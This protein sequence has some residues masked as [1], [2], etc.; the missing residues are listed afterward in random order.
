MAELIVQTTNLCKRYGSLMAVNGVAMSVEQGAIVGL[1]GKNGAGKTTLIRLLVGLTK[2]TSGTFSILPNRIRKSSSAAAIVEKPSLYMNM[3][4]I[5]NLR[6]QCLLLDISADDEFLKKTLQVVGLKSSTLKVKNFSLGMKQ[7]LAIAMSFVGK[8]ELLL[9]DEPTNGLD[10]Q[11]IFEVREAFV[12]LNKEF[13][14]TIIVSSHILSELS[15]FATEYYFMDKGRI[16]KHASA[17]EINNAVTRCLRLTVDDP[18]KAQS[19]LEQFGD[20]SVAG[21]T[22]DVFGD[23]SPSDIFLALS[24]AGVTVSDFEKIGSDLEQYFL[25][26]IGGAQ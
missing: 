8:P 6:A 21:N 12:Q 19:V 24:Q 11:G 20:T 2:P 9:L 4:A 14:T 5:D 1:V 7:R 26:I 15:K 18:E 17:E 10:P 3:T 22:V 16:V 25:Q 23:S 13:G